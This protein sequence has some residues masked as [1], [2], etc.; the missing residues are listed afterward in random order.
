ME[1]AIVGLSGQRVAVW[2]RSPAPG[3]IVVVNKITALYP[4]VQIHLR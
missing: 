1:E 2:V 3:G 4:G